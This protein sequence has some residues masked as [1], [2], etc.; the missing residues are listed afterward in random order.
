MMLPI[1]SKGMTW[2]LIMSITILAMPMLLLANDTG[3]AP[4]IERLKQIRQMQSQNDLAEK[5]KAN[6]MEV[7]ATPEQE[8]MLRLS[9][10]LAAV[11]GEKA[12]TL[13]RSHSIGRS[14]SEIQ[15]P[16]T[17]QSSSLREVIFGSGVMAAAGDTLLYF[18]FL[19]GE[20]SA[21]SL[22]MDIRIT[23]NEGT[24]FSNEYANY[25]DPSMLFWLADSGS[26]DDVTT[27][28]IWGDLDF[29][30]TAATWSWLGGN[31]GQPLGLHNIW[32]VY[33]RTSNMYVALEV[34]YV[35]PWNT[36][37]EFDY[38]I[39]TDG[40]NI[41]DD[42]PS[43]LDLTVNGLDADTLEVGSNPYFE[44][45]LDDDP[46][47]ALVIFYDTNHDGFWDDNDIPLEEYE[48]M[49]NDVHDEDPTDG[50]FG[51]TYDD[52]MA[53]GLNYFAS[54]LIFAIFSGMDY[55][56][57]SVTFY[58][59]PTPFSVS[60]FVYDGT[61]GM[62]P[63]LDIIV[64]ASMEWDD[65]GPSIIGVTDSTGYYHLDLPDSGWVYVGSE[66]HLGATDGLIPAQT[67]YELEVYGHVDFVDFIYETPS[68]IIQGYVLDEMNQPLIDVEVMAHGP[69]PDFTAWTNEY[70]FY[71]IGV[72]PGWYDVEVDWRSLPG[73]YMLPFMDEIEVN[74]DEIVDHDI[75]LHT[76]NSSISGGLFLDETPLADGAVFAWHP[77]YGYSITMSDVD[78]LYV[79]PVLDMGGTLYDMDA[80]LHDMDNVV[81]V[82]EN[83][84]V[85]AGATDEDIHLVTLFGGLNGYF[86]DGETGAPINDP[87]EIGM[88]LRNLDTGHEYHTGPDQDGYYEI[89]VPDG[90][91]EIMAGGMAWYMDGV[92]SVLVDGMQ[93]D[94]DVILW[95]IGFDTFIEGY[96]FDQFGN[97]I[98]DAHVSI[99]NQH[100]GGDTQTDDMG[101]YHF[102]VPYGYYTISAHAQDYYD[103][104]YDV[105]LTGGPVFHD[106]Y[107][108]A[109]EVD[110]VIAGL[111]FDFDT[112][113]PLADANVYINSEQMGWHWY[114]DDSGEFMFDLPNGDYSLF[115][116]HPDF[117]SFWL[118]GI[119]V[120][121][122]TVY[123][124]VPLMTPDGGVDGF[125]YDSD[126]GYPIQNAD[127]TL[128]R[129]AD[130][131]MFWGNTDDEGYYEIPAMNGDYD[132]WASAQDHQPSE[133]QPI[134][135]SDNW[136][137]MDFYLDFH[138]FAM[139]PMFNFI[140]DQ[141]NDQGRQV[142]MNFW[143]GGTDWGPFAGYSIWRMTH[144]PMGDAFDF[145]DY[146]PNHDFSEYM[147]V[148]PTLVDS[149]AYV[150]DPADFVSLF[151]VT[152]HWD[153]F[154]YMDG[155]PMGGYSIDNIHPGVPGQL[156]LLSSTED[157]VGI[158]WEMS[159]DDDFQYFEVYRAT[160]PD[161]TDAS[162]YATV[163][164]AYQDE[165]VTIGQTYY[166]A[167]SAVD[168]NGNMSETT[169]VITTS[170]VSVDALEAIPTAY[171]L[172]QNY[173]NPFNPTTSIEFAL[174]E[175]SEV[176]LEIYNLLGQKVRTLVNGYVPAGYVSTSWDGLDQNGREISSGTYIYRLQTGDQVFSKKMVL[177][178]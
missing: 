75:F 5:L 139:P 150:T 77:D 79:L 91:Y 87:R 81:Q 39:Q 31:D 82:S 20:N 154:G 25:S 56:D 43:T 136:I 62:A 67:N 149:N 141:P 86:I 175:A 98:E 51:F 55:A 165:D 164:P 49:D 128:F 59:L 80:K 130:S 54:D 66:D 8:R 173:P 108:E 93:I 52:E 169:N 140:V 135:I 176:S 10:A 117:I 88:G 94:Y 26:L 147:L 27:V 116:E 172:S 104:W 126:Q 138:Q 74:E 153:A 174:P 84:D 22:G 16:Q 64:Y 57:V 151:M 109:F 50:I 146:I 166:Y 95:P 40:S 58:S 1:K 158:G 7:N 161:F 35:E 38:L 171:G 132:I 90:L 160:N 4:D 137:S 131:M 12:P 42:T 162:V 97:P 48:F 45:S 152:G 83:W 19:T 65:E 121:D 123:I 17:S 102:D 107:L 29:M 111:V 85:P 119:I 100:W 41:F 177:M 71:S 13:T 168:A 92:D 134:N 6:S 69:G 113:Q 159:M 28:P 9:K 170:I 23:N 101:F 14:R 157:G 155:P 53:D 125:V 2:L 46:I 120:E 11:T 3:S 68:S 178:K 122:D 70:G 37:I 73:S 145:V 47:G 18:N 133:M 114:T 78:G 115:V 143:P 118:H 99:G 110:G 30:W 142:R 106:F 89:W 32:V 60:G 103:D 112:G 76:T 44:A 129:L 34:T 127:V 21:D 167:V 144:T 15:I 124:E 63:L 24:N 148:A 96:V 72:M 61:D 105:D 33:T 163:E 156:T 36:Y